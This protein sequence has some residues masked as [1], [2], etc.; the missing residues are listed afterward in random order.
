MTTSFPLR[1]GV[2][3]VGRRRTMSKRALATE[4]TVEDARPLKLAKM[5]ALLARDHG[6]EATRRKSSRPPWNLP[7]Q[8]T[9]LAAALAQHEPEATAECRRALG[10]A[11]TARGSVRSR[12][13]NTRE[14]LPRIRRSTCRRGAR[15]RFGARQLRLPPGQRVAVALASKAGAATVNRKRTSTA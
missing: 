14:G 7:V 13:P 15:H 9:D 10:V 4:P 6:V 2:G 11:I 3:T 12:T 5:R 1:D 8:K